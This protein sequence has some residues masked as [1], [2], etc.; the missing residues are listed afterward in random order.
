MC[1][2]KGGIRAGA[3]PEKGNEH[4]QMCDYLSQ[5]EWLCKLGLLGLEKKLLRGKRQK[6]YEWYGE[7][8]IQS[9]S[10]AT[11]WKQED[12]FWNLSLSTSHYSKNCWRK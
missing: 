11:I 1:A 4:S 10:Y 3:G 5:G 2:Q 12:P 7:V 9:K 6:N 8:R